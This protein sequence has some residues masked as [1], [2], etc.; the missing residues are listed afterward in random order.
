MALRCRRAHTLSSPG[1]IH[2]PL[3]SIVLILNG[4]DYGCSRLAAARFTQDHCNAFAYSPAFFFYQSLTERTTKEK[5]AIAPV[6][7]DLSTYT[8]LVPI[9]RNLHNQI[10]FG[11]FISGLR[12][13]DRAMGR[14]L[15]ACVSNS[16]CIRFSGGCGA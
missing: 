6:P 2:L 13:T 3:R 11:A 8:L 5:L 4:Q 7:M 15:N 16:L 1:M 12:D 9:F 10:C 14:S